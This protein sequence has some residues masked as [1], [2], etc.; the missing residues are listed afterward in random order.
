MA[1][2]FLHLEENII[3]KNLNKKQ[4][5]QLLNILNLVKENVS[6][7]IIRKHVNILIN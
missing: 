7:D 3:Q 6:L 5:N 2:K 1:L 4:E